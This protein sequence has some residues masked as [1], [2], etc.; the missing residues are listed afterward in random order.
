MRTYYGQLDLET[1]TLRNVLQLQ[2]KQ[3][4]SSSSLGYPYRW[5]SLRRAS[6]D[7]SP[8]SGGRLLYRAQG[9]YAPKAL[10]LSLKR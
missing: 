4:M 1:V 3:H 2:A 6:S 5:R 9:L 8:R 7:P 10:A